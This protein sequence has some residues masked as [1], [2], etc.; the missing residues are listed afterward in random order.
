MSKSMYTYVYPKNFGNLFG[1]DRYYNSTY[2]ITN[3]PQNKFSPTLVFGY[4]EF[5]IDDIKR[6][7]DL[8]QLYS[9]K[10]FEPNE[11]KY[12][13]SLFGTNMIAF[14][15]HLSKRIFG[16]NGYNYLNV[17]AIE[18]SKED[19]EPHRFYNKLKFERYGFYKS[20]GL[21]SKETAK[22]LFG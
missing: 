19:K 2:V 21:L 20:S 5:E 1:I 14:G 9:S 18:E 17:P 16:P 6:C 13:T 22:K 12:K 7:L 8:A 3:I 11:E 15:F 10:Y 4:A